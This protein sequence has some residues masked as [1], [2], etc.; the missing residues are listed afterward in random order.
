MHSQCKAELEHPAKRMDDLQ[1]RSA[2]RTENNSGAQ[3]V[4][5]L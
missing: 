5:M 1:S 2:S 4:E 3:K